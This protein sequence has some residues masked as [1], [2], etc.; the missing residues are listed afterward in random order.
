M[1]TIKPVPFVAQSLVLIHDSHEL[2]KG[3]W[4]VDLSFARRKMSARKFRPAVQS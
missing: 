4:N 1:G 2:R 3:I